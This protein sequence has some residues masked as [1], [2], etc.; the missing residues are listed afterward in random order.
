MEP[1]QRLILPTFQHEAFSQ[2][3]LYPL[4]FA[5]LVFIGFLIVA[6]ASQKAVNEMSEADKL[7]FN[8]RSK[9]F[10]LL[11]DANGVVVS[12]SLFLVFT[13][14]VTIILFIEC[15]Q[16]LFN[17]GSF[18]WCFFIEGLTL[19]LLFWIID[20]IAQ[21]VAHKASDKVLRIGK[22]FFW[23][24]YYFPFFLTIRKL[25][26]SRMGVIGRQTSRSTVQVASGE[27]AKAIELTIEEDFTKEEH[28]I[29]D[30]IVKFGNTDARQIMRSR[31]D[32]ISI[33]KN[34]NFD[35]VM[36][37]I[38]EHGYSR[39]PVFE[40]RQDNVIGVL[41]IKDLLPFLDE[42]LTFNWQQ[43]IRDPYYIPETKM[44]DDLLRDFQK[45][46]SH[47]A[48]VVDEYGGTSGIVTLEDVLEEILGDISDEF[49]DEDVIYSKIDDMTYVFEGRTTLN[50]FYKI[51]GV[52]EEKF[53]ERKGDSETI[54]GFI[55]ET[56]GKILK[57]NEMMEVDGV[58]L[59]V[60]SSDKRRVKLI[61]VVLK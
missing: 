43:L 23:I 12:I 31:I 13:Q 52:D 28:K 34:L 14:V 48:I 53:E 33:N 21:F 57:N 5:L 41:N 2:W 46:K 56:N 3:M 60:E 45:M 59:I 20:F 47:I 4:L 7:R 61:K 49:D 10:D 27:L 42:E 18:A 32:L 38:R 29:F 36:D 35:Q 8:E 15:W 44:I 17:C 50:D 22:I 11:K 51:T 54:G 55:V 39:I 37:L 58:K 25:A 24:F 26:G 6:S 19:L 30:G 16:V 9:H 40:N 1:P